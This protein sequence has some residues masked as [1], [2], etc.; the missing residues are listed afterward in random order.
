MRTIVAALAALVLW[1]GTAIAQCCGDCNGDGRV[2]IS[3]LVTAVNNALDNCGAPTSTPTR[4]PT[5]TPTPQNRCPSTFTN[6]QGACLFNGRFNQGCGASL[7]STFNSN[8]S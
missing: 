7:S 8:G 5:A 1:T 2:S 4:I 3:D 6:N